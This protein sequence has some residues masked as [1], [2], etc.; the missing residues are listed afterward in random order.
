MEDKTRSPTQLV[1]AIGNCRARI[2]WSSAISH[3]SLDD[4][5]G[6]LRFKIAPFSLPKISMQ[7]CWAAEG[8][9]LFFCI[10]LWDKDILPADTPVIGKGAEKG[11]R[12]V[13]LNLEL[14]NYIKI[15]S[16]HH[17]LMWYI[18]SKMELC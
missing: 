7:C 3:S 2:S 13:K 10:R 4:M 9:D 11:A 1:T 8:C 6:E 5:S 18:L 15:S 17:C 12:N 14:T 16:T